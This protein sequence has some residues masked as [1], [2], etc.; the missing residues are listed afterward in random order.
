MYTYQ[1]KEKKETNMM[2]GETN[3]TPERQKEIVELMCSVVET[4]NRQMASQQGPEELAKIEDWLKTQRPQ[5]QMMNENIFR[6][7][8]EHDII[9]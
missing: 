5:L 8:V 3:L 1:K 6:T 2:G 7:L 9:K 4:I